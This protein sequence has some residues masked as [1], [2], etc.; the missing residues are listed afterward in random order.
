VEELGTM[1]IKLQV[2]GIEKV[3]RQ[4]K[5]LDMVSFKV[6]GGNIV[7]LLGVNGAGKTTLLRILAGLEPFSKGSISINGAL[8]EPQDLRKVST[9]VFQK[10]V[11][12]NRNVYDNLAFGLKIRGK[13]DMEIAQMV[14]EALN[15]VGLT[16]FQKRKARK[17]SGG[18]QQRISLARAFLLDPRV[19]LLDEP[20]ANLDPNSARIIEKAIINHKC[21]DTIIIMATHNLGQ[22]K[23]L[24]D[25]VI[26]MHSGDIVE[27]AAPKD[28]FDNPQHEI[29]KKFVRGELEF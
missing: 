11:M 13:T 7:V 10:T 22:A 15:S 24:A 27:A 23:R 29:T 2:E 9:L 28:L 3:Y 14:S 26:H 20:T 4:S 25:Q 8:M 6:E 16:D 18:E 21:S 5:A 1:S 12:F 17:T 19:L